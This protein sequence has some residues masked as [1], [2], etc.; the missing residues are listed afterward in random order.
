M[1]SKALPLN[2]TL[3]ALCL[4]LAGLFSLPARAELSTEAFEKQLDLSIRS[5]CHGYMV[6]ALPDFLSDARDWLNESSPFCQTVRT[7]GQNRSAYAELKRQNSSLD[8]RQDPEYRIK[9][10]S[11]YNADLYRHSDCNDWMCEQ[12]RNRA[13]SAGHP[14]SLSDY[15]QVEQYCGGRYGCIESWFKS[16]PRALPQAKP[17]NNG[18]SLDQ[19]MAGGGTSGTANNSQPAT[20]GLSL[21]SML[22]TPE[23]SAQPA[24]QPSAGSLD[25]SL[26]LEQPAKRAQDATSGSVSL[27][28]VFEGR[29]QM[30]MEELS[31]DLN[32]FNDQ[33]QK[34]CT[35]SLGNSGCYQLPAESL[36]AKANETE[37][38]RYAACTEWQQAR[39]EQPANSDLLN[40]LLTR[41]VHLNERVDD[42]DEGMEKRIAAWQ[43]ERRQMIAQQ[44]QEAED[45]SNSAFFAG[46]ATVL[47]QTGAVANGSLSAEQAAQ[48]AFNVTQSIE[49]GEDWASSMGSALTSSI[50]QYSSPQID[51]NIGS[52]MPAASGTQAQA[53]QPRAVAQ[54]QSLASSRYAVCTTERS[55]TAVT[56]GCIGFR[57]ENNGSSAC[58]GPNCADSLAELCRQVGAR[59]GTP[60]QWWASG[61]GTFASMGQC[62]AKCEND[63]GVANWG[64]YGRK[65]LGSVSQ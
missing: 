30:A 36:L 21:D 50:P 9:Y 1:F 59:T 56:A 58:S 34:A 3:L 32:Y 13:Y 61:L 49:N 65:C 23:T 62:I 39:Q 41:V 22:G 20:G 33:M 54:A 63:Y 8:Y 44:Q 55:G 37:Q 40:N 43:E 31:V 16:W 35:C 10:L 47:L 2:T 6:D 60:L 15:K 42:L 46:V 38:Q 29:E 11:G 5:A 18:M 26:A 24:A 17:Q 48:N 14:I 28:S 4:L 64:Q 27:D 45:R 57:E 53:A 52:G 19:L 12:V 51:S 25:A 7:L